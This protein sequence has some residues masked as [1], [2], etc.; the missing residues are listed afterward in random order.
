MKKIKTK[1]EIMKQIKI[2]IQ[3]IKEFFEKV[4]SMTDKS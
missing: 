3:R 2:T 1:E 4:V